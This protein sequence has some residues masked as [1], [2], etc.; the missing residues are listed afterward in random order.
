MTASGS[1]GR[2]R[3]F[4]LAALVLLLAVFAGGVG[5]VLLDRLVLLPGHVR[6]PGFGHGPGGHPPRNREFRNRFA[7]ELGL[8]SE[9]Q[10]RIDSIMDRQGRELRAVR[11][12]VQ[13][14][15]DSIIKRTRRALDSVLTADQRKKA[16][17]LR[18]RH[19]RPPGPPPGGPESDAPGEPPPGPPPH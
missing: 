8:S 13:P 3:G 2:P 1:A 16:A 10:E 4:W 17:D 19:P 9:Q 15:V 14:E 11:G 7:R 5:G 12:R 6:G 18:R